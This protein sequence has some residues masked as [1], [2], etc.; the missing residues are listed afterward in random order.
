MIE[1]KGEREKGASAVQARSGSPTMTRRRLLSSA[2]QIT[3]FAML[4]TACM[5]IIN[6]PFADGTFWTDGQGWSD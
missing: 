2:G 5:P 3:F 4:P 1:V 6:A